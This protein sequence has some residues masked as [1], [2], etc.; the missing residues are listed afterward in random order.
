LV[1]LDL[2]AL[3]VAKAPRE[4]RETLVQPV[5]MEPKEILVRKDQLVQ[6]DLRVVKVIMAPRET[7]VKMALLVL[8]DPRVTLVLRVLLALLVPLALLAL[9]A[10]K[11]RKAVLEHRVPPVHR[12]LLGKKEKKAPL[13][14]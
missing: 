11:V 2:L 12:D 4:L 1:L 6:L 9:R 7:K 14:P 8:K 10:G 3:R 13:D 5:L